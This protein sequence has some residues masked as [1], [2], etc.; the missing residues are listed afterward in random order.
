MVRPSYA[1]PRKEDLRLGFVGIA[2]AGCITPTYSQVC[3]LVAGFLAQRRAVVSRGCRRGRSC[4]RATRETRRTGRNW[5]SNSSFAVVQ[6]R[7]HDDSAGVNDILAHAFAA[8]GQTDAIARNRASA[9]LEDLLRLASFLR[10]DGRS[11][12]VPAVMARRWA[13]DAARADHR[14]TRHPMSAGPMVPRYM[15]PRNRPSTATARPFTDSSR[16]PC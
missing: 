11:R 13:L 1:N 15:A 2:N 8:V 3:G 10:A 14:A 5:R 6:R 16:C 7:Q 9:A 12:S 4:R